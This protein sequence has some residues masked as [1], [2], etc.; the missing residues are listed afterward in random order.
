MVISSIKL[1]NV[2]LVKRYTFVTLNE[3]YFGDAR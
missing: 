3:D 1:H 2:L